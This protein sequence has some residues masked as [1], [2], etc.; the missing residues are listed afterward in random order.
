VPRVNRAAALAPERIGRD[1]GVNEVS[2]CGDTRNRLSRVVPRDSISSLKSGDGIFVFAPGYGQIHT[3]CDSSANEAN[4]KNRKWLPPTYL[5]LSIAVMVI[6]HFLLPLAKVIPA[7]W[8]YLGVIPFALGAAMN[9]IADSAFKKRGTTVKPF[10]PSTALITD[11]VFRI[12]R[13]PMYLG[14][15][16]ILAGL[17]IFMGS[18][19]PF[20]AVVAFAILMDILFIRGEERMLEEQFAESWS[21]YKLKT[22]RW[23]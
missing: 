10:E 8:S 11:G 13:N 3:H 4:M 9:I 20:G 6:L 5:Y 19:T 14:F 17:A 21:E 7:P 2:R 12:S 23:I 1:G 22:R 16:L 18:L 15:V